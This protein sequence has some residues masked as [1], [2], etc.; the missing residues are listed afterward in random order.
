[1]CVC[2]TYFHKLFKWTDLASGSSGIFTLHNSLFLCLGWTVDTWIFFRV[3]Q[4]CCLLRFFIFIHHA[5]LQSTSKIEYSWREEEEEHQ[6]EC[7]NRCKKERNTSMDIIICVR[8]LKTKE[9]RRDLFNVTLQVLFCKLVIAAA[10]WPSIGH[11]CELFAKEISLFLY[12]QSL[13][14]FHRRGTC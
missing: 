12:E 13:A 7:K 10:A 5:K 3:V 14:N 8:V 11:P 2:V 4:V 9:T 1:M 6:M